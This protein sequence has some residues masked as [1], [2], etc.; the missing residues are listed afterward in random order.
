MRIKCLFILFPLRY[1]IFF[2]PEERCVSHVPQVIQACDQ[3]NFVSSNNFH[4]LI[5]IHMRSESRQWSASIL[6]I[7]IVF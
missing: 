3:I 5:K 6:N 4:V 1:V 2:V 7:G